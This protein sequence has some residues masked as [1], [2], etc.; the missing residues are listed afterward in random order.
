MT[1]PDPVGERSGE[2]FMPAVVVV[3]DVIEARL[4]LRQSPGARQTPSEIAVA[5]LDGLEAAGFLV[6]R[7]AAS[8]DLYAKEASR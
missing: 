3:A 4:A 2:A 8:G 6:R 7:A 1:T 5:V